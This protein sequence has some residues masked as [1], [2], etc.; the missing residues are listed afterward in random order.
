MSKVKLICFFVP[1]VLIL[2]FWINTIL[3]ISDHIYDWNDPLYI[4]WVVQNNLKHIHTLDISRIY[5]T[6]AMYPFRYSLS[7][8]EQF[9][10][11]SII[12]LFLSIFTQNPISQLNV[13]LIINH[14]AIFLSF[15]LL[16]GI[17]TR[18]F[19][20]RLIS[21]FYISFSP[22]FISQLGHVQMIF[23]WPTFLSLYYLMRKY[24]SSKYRDMVLTGILMACQFMSSIYLGVMGL[25][26]IALYFLANLIFEG[27][28]KK[29]IIA[30][31]IVLISFVITASVSL[32]GYLIAKAE[33][34]GHR[35]MDEFITYSAHLSDYLFTQ[36]GQ[37]SFIYSTLPIQSI[38]GRFDKHVTGEK[39]AFIGIIPSLFILMALFKI[40]KSRSELK[41]QVNMTQIKFF[42]VV[43]MICGFIFSLG[44]RLSVNGTYL[45]IPLPYYFV[46]KTVPLIES[47]RAV[48]RWSFLVNLAA[49]FLLSI[50]ISGVIDYLNK[51]TSSKKV[52]IFIGALFLL[53]ILEFYP[54]P[55][56]VTTKSWWDQSYIFMKNDLC[57]DKSPVLEYPFIYRKADADIFK[58]LQYKMVILLASTQHDCFVLSG[59]S[60]YEP[61]EYVKLKEQL[62]QTPTE[63]NLEK[64]R[65]IGLKYL[66]INKFA[67]PETESQQITRKL[68]LMKLKSNYKD[69]RVEIFDLNNR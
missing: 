55:L 50:G 34:G 4:I 62:D 69:G 45:H 12:V 8:A 13:L 7:F 28:V 56:S 48:A 51:K 15:Y 22:Y 3:N 40:S 20:A 37:T 68:E 23:Y 6:T 29:Q 1:I 59:F 46:L 19:W 67:L 18:N 24:T 52:S 2:G 25:F 30:F 42:A 66:K 33:H 27:L 39:A 26:I 17:V 14:L 64:M 32:N 41:L 43:L 35:N 47:L 53:M 36:G 31:G 44:P 54:K 11:P 60:G 63:N 65:E 58:D 57:Q 10:F 38:W 61:E 5:D 16:V 9:F 49:A 21:A